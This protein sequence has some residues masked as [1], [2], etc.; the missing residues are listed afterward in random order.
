[1]KHACIVYPHFAGLWSMINK[2]VT[3]AERYANVHVAWQGGHLYDPT[4]AQGNFWD[5][6]FENNGP[7]LPDAEPVTD[8]PDMWLTY[9]N[10][11]KLYVQEDQSWRHTCNAIWRGFGI[12]REFE[13]DAALLMRSWPYVSAMIRSG[14]HGGEQPSGKLQ[15]WEQYGEAIDAALAE[16]KGAGLYIAASDWE[17]VLWARERYPGVVIHPNVKRAA[18]RADEYHL[19][20]PSTFEDAGHCMAEVLALSQAVALIHP[21]S[22]MA[23]A[24]LYINP[25]VKS[26][27]LP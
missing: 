20:N 22:N 21:V 13:R 9:K 6:L 12:R 10:P 16:Y 2:V 24:A 27:Y 7:R 26:I 11:A 25:T 1:M 17:S 14:W 23:T 15:T 4:G 3:C 8:Y 18:T 19:S 5:Y